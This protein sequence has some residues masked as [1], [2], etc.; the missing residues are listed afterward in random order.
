M[1]N[2][3]KGTRVWNL[4]KC[5]IVPQSEL[6]ARERKALDAAI[7]LNWHNQRVEERN[8][9]R[10][11]TSPNAA[12][13]PDIR[14]WESDDMVEYFL[15]KLGGV[16]PSTGRKMKPDEL[17][18]DRTLDKDSKYKEL[19]TCPLPKSLND[20]VF[21]ASNIF[22]NEERIK[23]E[24][25][26][27]G[28]SVET[29]LRWFKT[30]VIREWVTMF[31]SKKVISFYQ[32]V[33]LF[34]Q[35]D[36]V[37]MGS[38]AVVPKNTLTKKSINGVMLPKSRQ[39]HKKLQ[40]IIAKLIHK[41]KA[42]ISGEWFLFKN[43]FVKNSCMV[44]QNGGMD[45]INNVLKRKRVLQ[46]GGPKD[47]ERRF[48]D[49]YGLTAL[50]ALQVNVFFTVTYTTRYTNN[51]PFVDQ[52]VYILRDVPNNL[53]EG[54]INTI[55]REY[56]ERQPYDTTVTK[57]EY[58]VTPVPAN[59]VH[60]MNQRMYGAVLNYYNLKIDPNE[61][62]DSNCVVTFLLH[63]YSKHIKTL[64]ESKLREI[65]SESEDELGDS[66]LQEEGVST[67]Q[68]QRFCQQY[69]ISMYAIDLSCNVF[70]RY[71][72][73]KRNHHC[74]S[75][76]YVCANQH[77]YPI[78]DEALRKSIFSQERQ[79]SCGKP[80]KRMSNK[81]IFDDTL[82]T[83]ID[84]PYEQLDS[85]ENVNVVY[86]GINDLTDLVVHLGE[87]E[88]VVYKT[89]TNNGKIVRLEYKNNVTI[90]LNKDYEKAKLL[91]EAMVIPFKNQNLITL[92]LEVFEIY[93]G[94][95]KIESTF[96]K[97]TRD[98]FFNYKKRVIVDT[99]YEPQR[100]ADLK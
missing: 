99:F 77:M 47:K 91:C 7:R 66:S 1:S 58:E 10:K 65:F 83:I 21:S 31:P 75:L 89:R 82:T 63:A 14:E 59:Q 36:M 60:I 46:D 57:I 22:R 33:T 42:S 53:V 80:F 12:W 2:F 94:D 64:S 96:N 93:K 81:K 24:L 18:C 26:H 11:V 90:E 39:E 44:R 23:N 74:P 27:R 86:T 85:L 35:S 8:R 72:P 67:T 15:V 38:G 43:K 17:A 32:N 88:H 34:E 54:R 71:I 29:D 52:K 100:G 50:F 51:H 56:C 20:M 28:M 68:V 4:Y 69:G 37:L 3:D 40:R 73:E 87:T 92:A 62:G 55:T 5:G 78:L 30:L 13:I 48:D 61:T 41:R 70:C 95:D 19:D 25:E 6:T 9:L 84:P 79:Q 97:D 16:Y 98:V 76:V 49:D 45:I